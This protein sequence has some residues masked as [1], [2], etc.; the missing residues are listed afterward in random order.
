MRQTNIWEG[1]EGSVFAVGEQGKARRETDGDGAEGT[2]SVCER[3]GEENERKV[4][5]REG[6]I[7]DQNR[8][9]IRQL[10]KTHFI[11]HAETQ[12]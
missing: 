8:S 5:G 9:L 12:N 3:F 1:T 2:E 11:Q 7:T 10:S 6:P 4:L